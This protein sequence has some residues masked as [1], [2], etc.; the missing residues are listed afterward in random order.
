MPKECYIVG[1]NPTNGEEEKC[2]KHAVA[3]DLCANH[4][5]QFKRGTLG[6]TNRQL[7]KGEGD[8]ITFR[9]PAKHKTAIAAIAERRQV[10]PADLYREGVRLV[11]M[12][13]GIAP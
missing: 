6:R 3:F 8:E 13:E 12:R 9:L 1:A 5:K 4:Y 7:P 2:G 10:N 11:L